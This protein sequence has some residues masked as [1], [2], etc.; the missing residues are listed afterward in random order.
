MKAVAVVLPQ[1]H[2]SHY[3]R[4]EFERI[5]Y[6]FVKSNPYYFSYWLYPYITLLTLALPHRESRTYCDAAYRLRRACALTIPK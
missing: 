2:L 4:I 3:E 1:G 6:D 5:G